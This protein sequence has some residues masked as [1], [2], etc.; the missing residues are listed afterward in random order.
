M[1]LA[2][3]RRMMAFDHWG[4]MVS[5]EAAAPV[6]ATVPASMRWLNHILGAK[7]VWLARVAG[8]DPPFS[9][10]P[11]F[12][13]DELRRQFDTARDGWAAFLDTQTDADIQRVIAYRNLKDQP[14]VSTLGDILAH[15]PIHGQHHRGQINADLRA[16]GVSPPTIDFIHAARSGAV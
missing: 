12:S 6:A 2:Y 9:V 13:A 10:N 15:L 5:L 4:N 8:G 16:A 3:H 11:T 1:T 14:M 7:R